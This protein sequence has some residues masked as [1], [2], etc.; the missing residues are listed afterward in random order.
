MNGNA[1]AVR[2]FMMG[3]GVQENVNL[4]PEPE[5]RPGAIRV[6]MV[7][8][9]A[10]NDYRRGGEENRTL[11]RS[12]AH[13]SVD[14]DANAKSRKAAMLGPSSHHTPM[15]NRWNCY[16]TDASILEFNEATPATTNSSDPPTEFGEDET[17]TKTNYTRQR[18][19]LKIVALLL[20]VITGVIGGWVVSSVIQ[21]KKN[22][23]NSQS[24]GSQNP[25]IHLMDIIAPT[26]A[27]CLILQDP[28]S[29]QAQALEWLQDHTIVMDPSK[30]TERLL[31]RYA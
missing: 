24:R 16:D 2:A 20:V 29:P 23:E 19:R 7:W 14:N 5:V 3:V 13:S 21:G 9:E 8:D 31:E 6:E 18:R 27:D 15:L 28:T 12:S 22:R 10:L 25:M 11:P 4:D 30:S 1:D 17:P 26:D